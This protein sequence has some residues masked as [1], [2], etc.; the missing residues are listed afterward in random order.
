[1]LNM[2]WEKEI[3]KWHHELNS[4]SFLLLALY[5]QG[6]HL[7]FFTSKQKRKTKWRLLSTFWLTDLNWSTQGMFR[8]QDD[9]LSGGVLTLLD[10][11]PEP[12]P[13]SLLAG[14]WPYPAGG[15]WSPAQRTHEAQDVTRCDK[16]ASAVAWKLSIN[17]VAVWERETSPRLSHK[18]LHIP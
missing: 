15:A 5:V 10:P 1:M 3:C 8:W 9:I 4:H 11:G 13:D 12:G 16:S 17:Q 14:P 18:M 2:M 6:S 7:I